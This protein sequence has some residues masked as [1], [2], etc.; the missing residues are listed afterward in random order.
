MRLLVVVI[1]TLACALAA[2]IFLKNHPGIFILS[3]GSTTIQGSFAFFIAS[4]FLFSIFLFLLFVF[5]TGLVGL[6]RNYRRWTKYRRY[7]ES[8]RLLTHGL[9]N[10]FEGNWQHAEKAFRKGAGYSKA[11][12]LNYLE[13]AK[14]AQQQGNI[15]QRDHYLRL[16]HEFAGDTSTAVG[17]TQAELQLDHNQT[18]Q[19]YAT[20]TNLQ[21]KGSGKDQANLM[22]LKACSD[23][24]EWKVV[25]EIVDNLGK[26]KLLRP[27]E[28]TSKQLQAYAGLLGKAGSTG[29]RKLLDETWK[30]IPRV[31]QKELYLLEVYVKE[32]L[33]YPETEDCEKLLRTVLKHNWDQELIRLYGMVKGEDSNR[34]QLFAEN[35]LKNHARD[36]A[37]LLT[38][39][40]LC[41]RN[42]LWGKSRSYLEECLEID[43][44]PEVYQE[45]ASLLEQQ[46]DH[47][48]A[49]ECYQKGLQQLTGIQDSTQPRLVQHFSDGVNVASGKWKAES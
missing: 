8:E 43:P 7:R 46:G 40:R 6:P 23:L 22:L 3:Y 42:S 19:A 44:S 45:L 21:A 28:V 25:L 36:P 38:S 14:S 30:E 15:Q 27:E 29:E 34:Q 1:V 9:L 24:K 20:L 31:L 13:A 26:K 35:L 37:L 18:E 12:M 2:G 48:A 39:G 16:A 32:R 41:R 10:S 17:L 33:K 11:P 4:V 5:A 49:A 47:A